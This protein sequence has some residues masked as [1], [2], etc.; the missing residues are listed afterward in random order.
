MARHFG[1]EFG[2]NLG[3]CLVGRA[4]HENVYKL[5]SLKDSQTLPGAN[6]L[7]PENR[8]IRRSMNAPFKEH[9]KRRNQIL[10]TAPMWD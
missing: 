10:A 5:I 6:P 9:S 4:A 1:D 7:Q 3:N 2:R 8:L